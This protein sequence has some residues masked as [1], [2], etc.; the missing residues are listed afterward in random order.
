VH[1]YWIV[2]FALC[3]LAKGPESS[4]IALSASQGELDALVIRNFWSFVCLWIG[5]AGKMLIYTIGG[6]VIQ[7]NLTLASVIYSGLA[8][9]STL[10]GA[11]S[12][13]LIWKTLYY[14]N[15]IFV[16]QN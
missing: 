8:T 10:L 1:Q 16:K 7:T 14:S 11:G 9:T 2:Y 4:R 5:T 3:S 12:S 15:T 6:A 13:M